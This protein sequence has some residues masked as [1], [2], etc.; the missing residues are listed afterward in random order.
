MGT[1]EK[2]HTEYLSYDSARVLVWKEIVRYIFELIPKPESVLELGAGYC[3]FINAVPASRRMAIDYWPEFKQY[4]GK[5]VICRVADIRTGLK[6]LKKTDFDLIVASNILEHLDMQY[7]EQVLIQ[8]HRI[9][10]PKGRLIII[11]P[12]FT[13]SYQHYFDDYTHKT[14]FTHISLA[15]LL[16]EKGYIIERVEKKFLPMTFK[17]RWPK[18]PFLVRLYFRIPFKFFAGQMLIIARK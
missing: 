14:V 18:W 16:L 6:K 1:S 11:Q 9:L 15:N 3:N 2:Y 7:V 12:N 17:S 5:G 13:Y 10:R 8:C 4:A